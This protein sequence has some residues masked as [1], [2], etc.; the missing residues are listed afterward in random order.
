MNRQAAAMATWAP[1]ILRKEN[2]VSDDHRPDLKNQAERERKKHGSYGE[3]PSLLV[4]AMTESDGGSPAA[5]DCQFFGSM[6][7]KAPPGDAQCPYDGWVLT[8]RER[9]LRL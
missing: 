3:K 9:G 7:R 2:G 8:G 6:D 4:R 1:V 5:G